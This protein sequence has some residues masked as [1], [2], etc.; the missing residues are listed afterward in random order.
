GTVRGGAGWE[1]FRERSLII[2]RE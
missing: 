2:A 1:C